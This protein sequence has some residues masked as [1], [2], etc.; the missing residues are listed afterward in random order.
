M[1]HQVIHD[2]HSIAYHNLYYL[3]IIQHGDR[4]DRENVYV[5]CELN[6]MNI[7]R[8][9]WQICETVQQMYLLVDLEIEYLRKRKSPGKDEDKCFPN[10]NIPSQL[11]LQW[12]SIIAS[13]D[14]CEASISLW[15]PYMKHY[16]CVWFWAFT[17]L[18]GI[19]Y[20][21]I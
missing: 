20:L 21:L 14:L 16:P 5:L 13:W 7:K 17:E 11:F 15:L 10:L 6:F 8:N 3:L 4:D 1:A 9:I 19:L 12:V 2:Y 18:C